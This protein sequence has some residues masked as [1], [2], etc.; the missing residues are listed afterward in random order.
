[1]TWVNEMDYPVLEAEPDEATRVRLGANAQAPAAVLEHLATDAAVVVRA[2]LALNP[3]APPRANQVLARDD[4]E[5]VRAL[6]ARKLAGLAPA[7]SGA[8]QSRLQHEAYDTLI[9]LVEDEA[10][11]VRAAIAEVIKQM[12][13]VPRGLI[14]R[15]ARDAAVPVSEPVI[16]LS[17]LL[18]TADLLA[19]VNTPPAAATAVA[20]ARRPDLNARVADAIATGEDNEAI[21]ALLGNPSAQ[22]REATLDALIARAA[23]HAEWHEPL[24]RRPA[25]PPRSA[26]ALSTIVATHLL[27]VL[28]SRA[29][30]EPKLVEELRRRLDQRLAEAAAPPAMRGETTTEQAVAEAH[31]LLQRGKLSEDRGARRGAARGAPAGHGIAG[32]GGRRAGAGGGSGGVAAQ[33]QGTGQPGVEGRLLDA[34]CRRVASR[35]GASV[36]DRGPGTGGGRNVSADGGGNALAGRFSAPDRAVMVVSH[37]F[38][39]CPL[40]LLWSPEATNR[41]SVPCPP[42]AL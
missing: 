42:V 4:D 19:L 26:R 20:V 8:E 38:F 12:P 6:L 29:D 31:R 36:A 5:R 25:L 33:R 23:D 34:A 21:R 22:I 41:W 3:A 7:L 10:V 37:G 40:T 15:L 1:M 18:T 28:A 14:L 2:A 17:P 35:A 39:C 13:D 27:Q 9:C 32:R 16:R 30:L 24:V 11:R